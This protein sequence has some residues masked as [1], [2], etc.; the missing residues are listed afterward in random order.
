MSHIRQLQRSNNYRSVGTTYL[1]N[2]KILKDKN[3]SDKVHR[4]YTLEKYIL[5]QSRI[6]RNHIVLIQALIE[7]TNLENKKVVLKISNTI[8][9][10][11][12]EYNISK[13]LKN[14]NRFIEYIDIH[15]CFDNSNS[16]SNLILFFHH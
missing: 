13:K 5:N 16:N 7:N 4:T 10:L 12:N 11:V 1:V 6:H 3:N 14:I 2:Y 15:T 9:K 8:E